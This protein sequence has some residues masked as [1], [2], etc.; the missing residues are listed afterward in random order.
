[1]PEH[2]ALNFLVTKNMIFFTK[3]NTKF[4]IW[5]FLLLSTRL[6][7][8]GVKFGTPVLEIVVQEMHTPSG[9]KFI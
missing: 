7:C 5:N 2:V 6:Q 1:M 4:G 3:F 8:T 9:K